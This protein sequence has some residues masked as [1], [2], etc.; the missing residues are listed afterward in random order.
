MWGERGVFLIHLIPEGRMRTQERMQSHV[1]PA[2]SRQRPETKGLRRE[3]A[4]LEAAN[5]VAAIPWM[6]SSIVGEEQMKGGF[7]TR[8]VGCWYQEVNCAG[9]I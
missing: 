9:F 6:L 3:E 8:Q 5:P 7:L 1:L 2:P 4:G